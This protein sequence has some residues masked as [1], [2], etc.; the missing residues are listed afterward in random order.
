M[1]TLI[2]S[3][4][5]VYGGKQPFD[6][7]SLVKT[8]ADLLL[9]ST[10]TYSK[11]DASTISTVYNGIIVGV[12]RDTD[13]SN[14]GVYFLYDPDCKSAK[15]TL[16]Y[17][18]ETYW[19]RLVSMSELNNSISELATLLRSEISAVVESALSEED[20]N[21]IVANQLESISSSIDALSGRVDEIASTIPTKTSQLT[22]DTGY[23]VSDDIS[24]KLDTA[25]YNEDK[26]NFISDIRN[27][28]ATKSAL[29]DAIQEVK[30]YA[31]DNDADTIYDDSEL[32]GLIDDKIDAVD[33]V[34][35]EE[36][37]A[38]LELVKNLQDSQYWIV[39]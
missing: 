37:N 13:I 1:A 2:S 23:I 8:K 20:V 10:W 19:H 21:R 36:Y 24:G 15:N 27:T 28:Y 17:N 18:D 16:R 34:S 22:N 30:K 6:P 7:R 38:L 33:A 26:Q 11:D 9:D 35:K 25:T 32:R 29:N 39:K 14:N 4:Q 31:D 3:N 5:Y 12:W